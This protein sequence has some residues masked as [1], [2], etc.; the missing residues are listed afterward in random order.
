MSEEEKKQVLNPGCSAMLNLF[1]SAIILIFVIWLLFVGDISEFFNGIRNFSLNEK[2]QAWGNVTAVYPPKKLDPNHILIFNAK[3]NAFSFSKLKQGEKKL[4]LTKK[5]IETQATVWE[6][7][8]SDIEF[9][10]LPYTKI[11]YNQE[12]VFMASESS[13]KAFSQ[14]DGREVWTKKLEDRI[15]PICENCLELIQNNLV[16]LTKDRILQGIAPQT[17]K[18]LWQVRLNTSN[19]SGLGFHNLEEQIALVDQVQNRANANT[20]FY[21]YNAKTGKVIQKLDLGQTNF[22][23][24]ISPDRYGESIYC[25]YEKDLQNTF[26][27]RNEVSN[28]KMTWQKSLP[29]KV[30]LRAKGIGEQT[31][32]VL[33]SREVFFNA[34]QDNIYRVILKSN[35]LTGE[36]KLLLKE[37]DYHLQV[38]QVLQSTVLIHVIKVR[39]S[40]KSE[41]WAIDINNGKKVWQQTLKSEEVFRN[42]NKTISPKGNWVFKLIPE[43][44]SIIEL[45]PDNNH[46][47]YS[48]L[49]I[50]N[51]KLL[52]EKE[53][54]IEGETIWTGTTWTGD[55]AYISLKDLFQINL[56]TG[57]IKKIW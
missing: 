22:M 20:A 38:I 13:L 37:E 39:G 5:E 31:S 57:E 9:L 10:S 52:L 29:K 51:G 48:I 40:A 4:Y 26:I 19:A 36:T 35:F 11:E 17:G 50:S 3:K 12:L 16:V 25:F 47:R 41:I 15:E 34:I 1:L 6:S 7:E 23:L 28:G 2:R 42:N 24:P 46:L 55:F 56:S 44:L 21:F 54:K 53:Y 33:G 8:L 32:M 49:D 45:T 27:Q 30:E 18:T 14:E 43:G